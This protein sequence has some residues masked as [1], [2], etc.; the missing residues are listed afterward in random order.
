MKETPTVGDACNITTG[1]LDS[2]HAVEAGKYP[3]FTCA[4]EPSSIDSYAFDDSVILI[5]GNNASGNFHVNRYKGK[6]N[7]YQRTYV[8]TAKP[9]YDLDY[10]FYS[11]KIGFRRLKEKAQGSQTK[12]L[13]LPILKAIPL[14]GRDLPLQQKIAS[15]LAVLDSKIQLNT[16]I[17]DELEL[18][19]KTLYEYWFVQ[20]DFPDQ[21]AKP[22]KSS[23]GKMGFSPK[24]KREVP[25]GWDSG[26]LGDVLSLEYGKPLKEEDRVGNRYPVL[27]SNGVVGYHEKY[28]V[29]GPG[30]IVGRKGS[31]GAV[32]WVEDSFYPIDTTF[33]VEDKL[34]VDK[35]YF[36]YLL[37]LRSSFQ[38]IESSSS[39]PGL[40]RNAVYLVKAVIP[41]IR[42]VRQFNEIVEPFFAKMKLCEAENKQLAELRD[43][44]LPRL[45]NGQIMVNERGNAKYVRQMT[46]VFVRA[47]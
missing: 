45:M 13:T 9:G 37:L 10:V 15:V 36:H 31:A 18:M 35:L 26:E 6:F 43:W 2:N 20:F 7:A 3:F 39:V 42:L 30:I 14:I 11:L 41:K 17:K 12:F 21:D 33:Y 24:L 25:E 47:E 40:N 8:L 29:R 22:Y 32:V 34:G 16:Q 38:N 5:A 28:L 46:P 27:G 4:P 19:A 44:L 1:K 23:G